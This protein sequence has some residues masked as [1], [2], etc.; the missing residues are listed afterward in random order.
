MSLTVG[1]TEGIAQAIGRRYPADD[2]TLRLDHTDRRLFK[3]R[4][5]AFGR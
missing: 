4:E 3:F 1:V 5:I 2:A